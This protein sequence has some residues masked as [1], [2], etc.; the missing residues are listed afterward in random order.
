MDFSITL[1]Y[2]DPFWG[3]LGLLLPLERCVP[4]VCGLRRAVDVV[5]RE[6]E[7]FVLCPGVFFVQRRVVMFA[8]FSGGIWGPCGGYGARRKKILAG[9]IKNWGGL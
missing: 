4:F 3:R 6:K 1:C 8:R 5:W 2:K 9:E 7:G